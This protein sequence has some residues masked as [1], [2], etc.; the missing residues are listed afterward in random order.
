MELFRSLLRI[1]STFRS[2]G[3]LYVFFNGQLI[4]SAASNAFAKDFTDHGFNFG[5]ISDHGT[6]YKYHKGIEGNIVILNAEMSDSDVTYDFNNQEAIIDMAL[7]N[8]NANFSFSPSNITACWAA[9]EG[10]GTVVN[11]LIGGSQTSI[12]NYTADC[13]SHNDSE[14]GIQNS[15]LKRDTNGIPTALADSGELEP[16]DGYIHIPTSTPVDY[17]I[18]KC[19]DE[20]KGSDT[21][22]ISK[23][24]D[25]SADVII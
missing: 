9:T 2:D 14:Y 13:W 7:G 16:S 6:V 17:N 12:A 1:I 5:Y 10:T 22:M 21:S 11:N 3:K 25:G 8:S 20:I 23:N 4:G 15:L 18:T 19:I 24:C